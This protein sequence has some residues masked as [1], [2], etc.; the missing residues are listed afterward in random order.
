MICIFLFRTQKERGR[1][2]TLPSVFPLIELFLSLRLL[3]GA[4][5]KTAVLSLGQTQGNHFPRM[6]ALKIAVLQARL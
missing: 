2:T 3:A 1:S 4:L 6:A 5:G